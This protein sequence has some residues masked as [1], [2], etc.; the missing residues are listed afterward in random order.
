MN[1]P[2]RLVLLGH[3]VSH[4][5]SPAIQNAALVVAGMA[6]NYETLDVEPAE[7]PATLDSL[8][9]AHAAGNITVPHKEAAARLIPLL[10]PLA[11]RV[12]AVNTFA[13]RVDGELHGDNTDVAGFAELV[14]SVL[15]KTPTAARFAIVGAGGSAAAVLAAI[16]T[17]NGCSATV[18]AR[19]AE[20]ATDLFWRFSDVARVETLRPGEPVPCDIVV[21]ATPIGLNDEKMPLPLASLPPHAV[22]LDLV[23]RPAETAWVRA[24]RA[25]GRIASDGLPMLIEQGAASFEAWFGVA[26][27][28]EAM[29]QAVTTVTGRSAATATRRE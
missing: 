18:Y 19:S 6:L 5:L 9:T 3:P 16:E 28:R 25:S 15:G 22:V 21:N 23:Y 10:S 7:L 4:S 14:R 8:R 27:S 13:T 11:E 20:R 12:G 26:P 2:R 24:A 17:W 1:E 29:W